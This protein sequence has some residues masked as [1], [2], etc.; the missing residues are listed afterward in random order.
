MSIVHYCDLCGVPLK[1][2]DYFRLY[3]ANVGELEKNYNTYEDYYH[4][5]QRAQNAVKDICPTCKEITD[6]I[7]EL[8]FQ[9]LFQLSNELMGMYKLENK[10]EEDNKGNR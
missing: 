1:N 3:V 4:Y 2:K 7:F 6:R 5:F 9:N 8:R 10:I